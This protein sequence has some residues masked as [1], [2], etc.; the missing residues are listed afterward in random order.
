MPVGINTGSYT[1]APTGIAIRSL[2][3]QYDLIMLGRGMVAYSADWFASCC[4]LFISVDFHEPLA[5]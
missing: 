3:F 2:A 5:A 1:V 4:V